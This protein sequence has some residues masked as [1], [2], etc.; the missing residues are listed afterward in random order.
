MERV[1]ITPKSCCFKPENKSVVS[2]LQP[3]TEI[4]GFIYNMLPLK[5]TST[6]PIFCVQGSQCFSPNYKTE[7]HLSV[8]N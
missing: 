2:V 1:L 7:V 8:L 5:M 3:L 6:E 4:I